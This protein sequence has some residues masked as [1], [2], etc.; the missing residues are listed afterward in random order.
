CA[1]SDS[2]GARNA[3]LRLTFGGAGTTP[4]DVARGEARDFSEGAPQGEAPEHGGLYRSLLRRSRRGPE[5]LR[6]R[7]APQLQGNRRRGGE[8]Q[9]RALD[10]QRGLHPDALREAR[11]CGGPA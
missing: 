7:R 3:P 8:L 9:F 1:Y 10:E 4:Q 5:R 6:Y 2:V 11:S